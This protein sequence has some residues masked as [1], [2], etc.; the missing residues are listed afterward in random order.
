MTRP[1]I[2]ITGLGVI[3]PGGVGRKAFWDSM[4]AGRS[5]TRRITLF[6]PTD[7]RC[8]VAGEVDFKPADHGLTPQ[9]IRRMDR[10]A[11]FAVAAAKEAVEDSGLTMSELVPE[12]TAVTVGNAVGCTMGLEQEYV[13]MSDGGRKWVVDHEYAVPHAY[14]YFAPSSLA[15]EVGW[16]CMAEGP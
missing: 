16:A 13:V 14:D 3:A 4:T 2:A 7:F 11:Q 5:A 15:R 6:D 1:P 12:R 9:E 8:H 10:T